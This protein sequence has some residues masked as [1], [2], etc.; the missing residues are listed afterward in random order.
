M[1]DSY[2]MRTISGAP[3][4]AWKM[5]LLGFQEKLLNFQQHIIQLKK[6]KD[7]W[8]NKKQIQT[9]HL[10]MT[11][12]ISKEIVSVGYEKQHVKIKLYNFQ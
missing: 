12:S 4:S 11:M 9:E 3:T 1:A 7:L 2:I 6:K 5:F 10:K 8:I